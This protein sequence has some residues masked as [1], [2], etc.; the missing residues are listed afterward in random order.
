MMTR[1]DILNAAAQVFSQKGF[2]A[3]SMQDIA[4]AVNLQKGSLY[5]H[6]NSKQEIL[7]LLLDHAL[8]LLI[9]RLEAVI[10]QPLPTEGKLRLAIAEYLTT[11]LEQ[12][13]LAAVLL[14]EHRNL[15]PEL[16][17]RHNLARDQFEGL[18]RSLVR[19]GMEEGVFCCMDPVIAV[20][21]IMGTINWTITW[22]RPSGALSPAQIADQ[23]A[24]L[25]LSGMLT[26]PPSPPIPQY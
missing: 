26:R 20:M 25:I 7:A 8:D 13:E 23:F 22:Y 4:E 11:I 5:H 18:W 15:D 14:L 12:K 10:A 6:V 21:A 9:K 2:H 16:A 24:G 19:Q 1:D 17:A 3:A